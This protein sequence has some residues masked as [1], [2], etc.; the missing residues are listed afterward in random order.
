MDLSKYPIVLPIPESAVTN[1]TTD[2]AAKA[3]LVSPTFTGT[4]GVG[5][6]IIQG[7]DFSISGNTGQVS[8]DNGA[9]TSD[10]GGNLAAGSL[11]L[12]GGSGNIIA[13]GSNLTGFA[14]SLTVGSATTSQTSQ[15]LNA[16]TSC[17]LNG[18]TLNIDG[19]SNLVGDGSGNDTLTCMSFAVTG[20]F[21]AEAGAIITGSG[22]LADPASSTPAATV[23]V[24]SNS[25]AH[26]ALLVW[27]DSA[28]ECFLQSV[29]WGTGLGA[30]F[31]NSG[32]GDIFLGNSG[33]QLVCYSAI[34]CDKAGTTKGGSTSGTAIFWEFAQGSANKEINIWLSA[35]VGTATLTF[36]TTFAQTPVVDLNSGLVSTAALAATFVTTLN[37]TTVTVTGTGSTGFIKIKGI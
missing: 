12:G 19:S 6:G 28:G 36:S 25:N 22:S 4:V 13:N 3:P 1:L 9:I 33:S 20:P 23:V 29:N 30:V 8:F 10:G 18:N 24:R 35:L 21:H 31:I 34:Q 26:S 2:L 37:T 16:N 5:D 15:A 7:D 27:S 32:G 17:N 11:N 14:S